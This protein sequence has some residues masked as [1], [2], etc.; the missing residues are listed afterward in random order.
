[1]IDVLQSNLSI[2][3]SLFDNLFNTLLSFP[4]EKPLYFE[5]N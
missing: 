3:N 2:P 5:M 4:L 1:M